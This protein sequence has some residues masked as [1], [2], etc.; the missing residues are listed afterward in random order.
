MRP[1]CVNFAEGKFPDFC[2]YTVSVRTA[3][4]NKP[5]LIKEPSITPTDGLCRLRYGARLRFK[6]SAITSLR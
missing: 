1:N 6:K 3:D 2:V 4:A 5:K